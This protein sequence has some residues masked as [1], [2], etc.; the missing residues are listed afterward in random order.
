MKSHVTRFL[1]L[2]VILCVSSLFSMEQ[3][4]SAL[5]KSFEDRATAFSSIKPL[6]AQPIRTIPHYLYEN[7]N[8]VTRYSWSPDHL[9]KLK[10]AVGT[11]KKEKLQ[12]KY[13]K[14]GVFEAQQYTSTAEGYDWVNALQL[15]GKEYLGKAIMQLSFDDLEKINAQVTR[16]TAKIPGEFRTEVIFWAHYKLQV[17]EC[18]LFELMLKLLLP[19]QLLNGEHFIIGDPETG[20]IT[21]ESIK[22]LLSFYKNDPE[23][24]EAAGKGWRDPET[25]KK[26]LEGDINPDIVDEWKKEQE[27][28]APEGSISFN[29]WLTRRCH[30]FP[31]PATVKERLEKTFLTIKMTNF[32]PFLKACILWFD[33]IRIHVFSEANKRTGRLLSSIIFLQ[34][35]FLPPLITKEDS[36]EFQKQLSDNFSKVDGAFNFAHYIAKLVQRTQADPELLAQ[37]P[38]EVRLQIAKQKEQGPLAKP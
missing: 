10:N 19:K 4:L 29:D 28:K 26:F 27:G 1:F 35:G 21:I 3:D 7:C 9:E 34:N 18:I 38:D 15:L 2:Y 6:S 13:T 23:T 33:I 30:F 25:A 31:N 5:K 16:L 37:L 17:E 20:T 22:K 8:Q 12:E 11:I 36:E 14:N 24:R 32:C